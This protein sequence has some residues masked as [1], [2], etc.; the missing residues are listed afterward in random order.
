VRK[1]RRT[2]AQSTEKL[3]RLRQELE[4]A[5]GLVK[6]VLQREQMRKSTLVIEQ[7]IFEQR[8]TSV[9][10]KRKLNIKDTDEDLINKVRFVLG[11]SCGIF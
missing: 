7:Q 10:L 6:D 2:D 5:R 9:Q 8:R 1:T 4:S 11:Y 3:K